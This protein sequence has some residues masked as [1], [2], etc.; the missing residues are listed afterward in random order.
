MLIL[1]GDGD[2]FIPVEDAAAMYRLIPN[3]ELAVAPNA[4]HSLPRTKIDMFADIVM[5][6][7]IRN[8]ARTMS[9]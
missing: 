3:A 9:A 5:E 1:I 7:L 6:F 4:D 2:Q 8:S